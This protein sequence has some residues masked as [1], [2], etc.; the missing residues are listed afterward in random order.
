MCLKCPARS[1]RTSD[2]TLNHYVFERSVTFHNGDGSTSPG[3][4]DLY[5]RGCFVMEAKQGSDR[6]ASR[7]PLFG[8]I[9][10]RAASSGRGR[11]GTAVRGMPGWDVAMHRA[12]G[13]AEQYARALPSEGGNPPFLAVVD[14]GNL[15]ELYSD[16]RRAG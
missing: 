12:R 8:E 3:R 1:P 16:F 5:R 10:G 15:F 7:A 14:V 13:Q 2:D 6:T 4:I 9:T 11:R